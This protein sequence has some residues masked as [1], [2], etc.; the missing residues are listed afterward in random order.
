MDIETLDNLRIVLD[1]KGQIA[2][3]VALML[4]MFGIALGLRPAHFASLLERRTV[5]L[6][7]VLTQ[8][9]GLPLVT[10]LLV[11]LLT[12]PPSMALGMFVVAC[13]PG[14]AVSNL[15]TYLAQGDV[16]YSVSLT[17]TSS[18]LAAFL[19]PVSILF[20]SQMY[21]PTSNLLRTIDF[22]ALAFLMQTTILLAVPLV[23]GM[24]LAVR[25]PLLATRIRKRITL[26]G[27]LVLGVA[28]AYGT[29]KFF[30]LLLPA[31]AMIATLTAIHNAFA[32]GSGALAGGLLR[33]DRA[34]RRALV[35]EVG[36]QNSGLAIVI[37]LGQFSG[38]GGAAAIAAVWG[39]WHLVAGGIIV[40]TYRY[41]D[42]ARAAA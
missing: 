8:V 21:P 15:F 22:H 4:I 11:T 41:R 23:L 38:L 35:F 6:G 10:L 29:A 20:W 3:A 26:A 28:I 18:V 37:L 19:T 27:T 1:P 40:L 12:P 9:L 7:G 14:G 31:L 39:V 5:F 42:R 13:C 25:A 34:T 2:I 30:A 33:A 24:L 36:I 17:A 32:F 16:A